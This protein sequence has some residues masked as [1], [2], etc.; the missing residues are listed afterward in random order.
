MLMFF[1]CIFK[2]PERKHSGAWLDQ[3]TGLSNAELRGAHL[4]L[5]GYADNGPTL[6]IFTYKDTRERKPVMANNTGFSHIAFEVGNVEQKYNEALQNGAI[7][8]GEVTEKT[9][10]G[11]GILKFV[12]IRDPEGNI[13]EIQSWSK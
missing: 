5:P 6:E 10:D 3:G 9:V 4:L 11:V 8:L 7:K 1:G 13:I 2:P 12:Y